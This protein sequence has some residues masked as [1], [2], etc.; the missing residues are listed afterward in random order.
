MK[1]EYKINTSDLFGY[2]DCGTH[3]TT[4][5]I[6]IIIYILA[7]YKIKNGNLEEKENT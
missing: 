1:Q 2:S 3:P 7:T 6:Y 4:Q 5:K